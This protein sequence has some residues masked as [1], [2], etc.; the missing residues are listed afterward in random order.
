MSEIPS[1]FLAV[2]GVLLFFGLL[3]PRLLSPLHL[4]FAT[5]LILVG[6]LMGPNGFGLVQPDDSLSL[7]AFLGGTFY[8]LLAGTEARALGLRSREREF[9][10]LLVPNTVVPMAVGVGIGRWFG[11]D[12]TASLFLGTVFLSSSIMLVF[13]MVSASGI[14]RSVAGRLLMRLAVAQDLTAAVLA[15][16]VFQT[17]D[18]NTRFPLP[19][20]AGLVFSSV[21]LLRMFLPEVVSFFFGRFEEKGGDDH[22]ARLRLV[23]A[24]FLLVIF[25]YSALDVHPIIAAFLVGFSLAEVPSQAIRDRLET[26]GYGLFIPVFLF[27]VGLDTDLRV[28]TRFDPANALAVSILVGALGSKVLS[29]FVGGLWGGLSRRNA[30]ITGVASGAKLAVPLTATYA[31]RDLGI[32]DADLFSA[33]IVASVIIAVVVPLAVAGLTHR[34]AE[35]GDA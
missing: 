13:G 9:V 14:G 35:L 33:I 21:V 8:M 2:L 17:L 4:P 25:A 11:Y 16:L 30:W 22:E 29:G 18:P 7:F 1:H 24:L 20:L 3:L 15:F 31:A 10:R 34:P 5:S 19:I 28:I 12:W 27:I 32:L 6:S 23:I 26:M